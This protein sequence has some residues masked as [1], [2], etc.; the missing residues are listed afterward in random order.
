MHGGS[1]STSY[2]NPFVI[3]LA[4]CLLS[5]FESIKW[6]GR[7]VNELAGAA[8]TCF[9]FHLV[10]IGRIGVKTYAAGPT[11]P[12]I[13]HFVLSVVLIYLV[14]YLLYKIYNLIFSPLIR[15][16]DRIHLSYEDTPL[17]VKK[18]NE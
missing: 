4:V 8:F 3:L 10:L 14:S 5:L 16:L 15:R 13:L 9:L 17:I 18:P 12:F 7:V 2:C 6:K 11:L 1:S